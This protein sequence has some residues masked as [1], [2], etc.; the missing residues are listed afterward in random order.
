MV[1]DGVSDA[2]LSIACFFR[3]GSAAAKL[4]LLRPSHAYE[5]G[6]GRFLEI[7]RLTAEA[8]ASGAF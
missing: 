7:R 1:A 8:V 5:A 2:T 6:R 4:Q 3:S